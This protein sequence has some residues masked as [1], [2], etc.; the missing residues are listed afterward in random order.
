MSRDFMSL[1]LE[2]TENDGK[3]ILKKIMVAVKIKSIN[4]QGKTPTHMEITHAKTIRKRN[5]IVFYVICPLS[6]YQ[7]SVYP[8]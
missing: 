1:R 5:K 6:A 4:N 2:D 7:Y 8:N 3:K